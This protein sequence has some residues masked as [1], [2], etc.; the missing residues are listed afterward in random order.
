MIRLLLSAFFGAFASGACFPVQCA[1]CAM[2]SVQRYWTTCK[3]KVCG[4]QREMR[5][6][7]SMTVALFWRFEAC[8][9]SGGFKVNR[10]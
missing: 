7:W 5:T 1:D 6:L 3:C 4:Q 2:C 9:M 10:Q 8:G